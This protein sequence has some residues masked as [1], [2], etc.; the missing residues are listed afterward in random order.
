MSAPSDHQ[1]F[2]LGDCGPF[3]IVGDVHGCFEELRNLLMQLGYEVTGCVD[4]GFSVVHPT[5]RRIVFLGDLNDRGPDTV[6]CLRIA[7][8]LA[9]SGQALW[10]LGNHEYRLARYLSGKRVKLNHGLKQTVAQ[11]QGV[12]PGFTDRLLVHLSTLKPSHL[13]D[14][15]RLAVAHAALPEEV[16]GL[17]SKDAWR[18]AVFGD[19]TGDLDENG[20]PEFKDW[21]SDYK[22]ESIVVHGHIPNP[23]PTIC[24]RVYG[25]DTGCV[26]GN[27]L[28]ALRYPELNLVQVPALRAYDVQM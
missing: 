14:Q 26:F 27:S 13:L 24:N 6:S 28:T 18:I 5:G 22:G 25:I 12:Q 9:E 20:L 19:T 4:T 11:L 15:G 16:Q 17:D 7:M 3:D 2:G 23:E 21:A 10:L 8:D 1:A